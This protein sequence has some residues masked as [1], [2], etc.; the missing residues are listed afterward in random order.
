ML[1]DDLLFQALHRVELIDPWRS[2]LQQAGVVGSSLLAGGVVLY[3]D[4]VALVCTSPLRTGLRSKGTAVAL[5][6]GGIGALG[7]CL[8]LLDVA[9]AGGIASTCLYRRIVSGHDLPFARQANDPH[10]VLLLDLAEENSAGVCTLRMR[11]LGAGWC[12][13]AYRA[14]LDGCIELVADGQGCEVECV[15]VSSS[16]DTLGYL[17][18][19]SAYPFALNGAYWKSAHP[20]DWPWPLAREWRSQPNSSEFRQIMKTALLAR[21]E[22]H[23]A[24]RRRLLALQCT[25]SV[26]GV[27][28][29]LI[30]EVAC[31]LRKER[32]VED[33]YA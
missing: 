14:D 29:G 6:S 33:S 13:L 20:R 24:L 5:A 26:A 19:S 27:P 3:F 4:D 30:E 22:Q 11:L 32:L 17:S 28:A 21:F 23:P 8:T 1:F 31:L 16:D 2:P 7:Y 18:P 15:T 25:V 9:E 12:E 10:T